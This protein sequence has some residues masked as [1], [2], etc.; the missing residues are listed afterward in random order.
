M[1]QHLH[2]NSLEGFSMFYKNFLTAVRSVR[3]QHQSPLRIQDSVKTG[4][5]A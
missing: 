3:K 2:S 1:P 4:G 5:V